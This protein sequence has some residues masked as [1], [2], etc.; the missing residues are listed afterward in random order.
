MTFTI[1]N[2]LIVICFFFFLLSAF[3][4]YLFKSANIFFKIIL[5]FIILASF[6]SLESANRIEVTI[7]AILGFLF[8]YFEPF[9]NFFY[10]LKV[11]LENG[12]IGFF[13]MI[14]RILRFILI[15]IANLFTGFYNFLSRVFKW[16]RV[17][18]PLSE[19]YPPKSSTDQGKAYRPRHKSRSHWRKRD[20]K[21]DSDSTNTPTQK[22]SQPDSRPSSG[23]AKSYRSGGKQSHQSNTQAK[24]RPTATSPADQQKQEAIRQAKDQVR[25][26]REQVKRK[27][28]QDDNGGNQRSYRQIL[29]LS[30][31]FTLAELV[32]AYKSLALKYH[33]DK[34]T[35]MSQSFQD[36]A[37]T[38]FIK[39]KNA[40][41][42]LKKTFN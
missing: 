12:V 26:A 37:K 5:F 2:Q 34:H 1:S 7:S 24:P 41:N 17:F 39:V 16:N 6:V 8:I 38:E 10:L 29:G 22:A 35:Q 40:Y 14:R 42:S 25:K 13:D 4:S 19:P 31:N 15:P 33:P 20:P 18:I 30:D 3:L 28:D 11:W 36:E 32:T 21:Q 23:R 9:L 27:D